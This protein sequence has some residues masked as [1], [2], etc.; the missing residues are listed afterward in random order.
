MSV[1]KR[2][3]DLH[4]AGWNFTDVGRIIGRETDGVHRPTRN[5]VRSW[6]DPDYAE[7][8]RLR[9]RTGRPRKSRRKGWRFVFDRVEEMR[10]LNISYR[11]IAVLISHD[12]DLS[13][14]EEQVR[15][16]LQGRMR[17]STMARLLWPKRASV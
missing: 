16:M 9:R 4:E 15:S 3:R 1:V 17:E 6:I 10:E 14:D 7:G 2:A 8:E 5:A 12:F 11:A 13:L